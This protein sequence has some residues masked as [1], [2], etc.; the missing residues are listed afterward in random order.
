MSVD[1]FGK[2]C[3]L[4]DKHLYYYKDEVPVPI[5]TM[6]D[7]ALAIT[8]CGYKASMMN[9]YLNTKTSI[10]KLQYGVEKCFKM[11]VGRKY[12]QEIC[13]DLYVNGWKLKTVSEVETG[14]FKQLDE[15]SGLHEMKKVDNEK[16]LGDIVTSD[17][18]NHKNMLARRNRGIGVVTQIMTKLEDICFGKYFLKWQ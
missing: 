6:V 13:P 1:S 12:N 8:E 16:Y 11:H 10:K 7:D 2:E 5:L 9:S 18:K 15:E 17:G 4:Q 3:L 14:L